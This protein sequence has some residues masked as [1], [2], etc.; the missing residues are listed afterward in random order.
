M[1]QYDG[2]VL[3]SV[4]GSDGVG[5]ITKNGQRGQRVLINPGYG[6]DSD[7]RGPERDFHILGLLPV[8][9]TFTKEEVIVEKEDIV[10]CPEFLSMTEAAALPLAG[11][12]A[13]RY[14]KVFCKKKLNFDRNVL[15]RSLFTKGLVQKGQHILITGIGGGVALFALQFAVAAGAHVYVTSSSPE[16]IQKSIELGAIGGVNY[17]DGKNSGFL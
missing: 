6:W 11:L 10:P 5:Y 4:L 14:Q 15:Y 17:K 8:I 9:G 13:Y 1:D 12:T 16:K 7:E 3:D 2:T